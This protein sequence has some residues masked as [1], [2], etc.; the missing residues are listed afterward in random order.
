MQDLSAPDLGREG[1][2]AGLPQ[3]EIKGRER[4]WA[5]EKLLGAGGCHGHARELPGFGTGYFPSKCGDN[6]QTQKE[7]FMKFS[8]SPDSLR[9]KETLKTGQR[10]HQVPRFRIL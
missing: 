5:W 10:S 2:A 7:T 6:S 4:P 1:R 3:A 8:L 9:V